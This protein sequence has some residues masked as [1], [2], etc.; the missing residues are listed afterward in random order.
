MLRRDALLD[1]SRWETASL[2][3]QGQILHRR[4]KTH[5][6]QEG[7]A[8]ST[9]T[10]LRPADAAVSPLDLYSYL[11]ARFGPPN[12]VMMAAR[13]PGLENLIQW[14][15]ALGSERHVFRVHGTSSRVEFMGERFSPEDWRALVTNI[16]QDFARFGPQMTKARRSMERWALFINPFRRIQ[17]TLMSLGSRLN[18]ISLREP[19]PRAMVMTR[20]Q[21]E[22]YNKEFGQW[23]SQTHAAAVL[24]TS[25]RML[26]PV[27]AEAFVNFVLFVQGRQ[28]VRCDARL[29]KSMLR[30]QIDVRVRGL[31]MH[32]DGFREAVDTS[33]TAF[34]EFHTLMNGRNAF[35]HG[36]IDPQQL[37]FDE[38]YLDRFAEDQTIPLFKDDRGMLARYLANSL[39][40][41]EPETALKDLK[42]VA[43]FIDHVLSHLSDDARNKL[44]LLLAQD[45]LG[46][47]DETGEVAQLFGTMLGESMLVADSP[48]RGVS[49]AKAPK[50]R[51]D[52]A[53]QRKQAASS[54]KKPRT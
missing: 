9:A 40:F 36:N 19:G 1:V 6:A 11:K 10:A 17:N 37:S 15:Y 51:R 20:A 3:Q 12:D 7:G 2:D 53:G 23:V 31:H 50:K 38:M 24:G 46:R 22:T 27:M 18:A 39:K 48:R 5:T 14:G 32:C 16:K 30:E 28:D 21:A 43:R 45:Y 34:A 35:L 44:T 29:Y 54:S 25:I 8:R 26:A 4:R 33:H 52:Q 42:T 13:A 47:N 41:V 49:R